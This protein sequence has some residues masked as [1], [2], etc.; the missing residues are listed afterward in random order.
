MHGNDAAGHVVVGDAVEAGLD[1]HALQGFLVRVHADR[2]GEVTVALGVI[3]DQ[4]ASQRHE[5]ERVGVVGLGHQLVGRLGELQDQQAATGLEHAQHRTDGGVL[6]GDVAQ[7]E[8]DGHAV[9]VVVRERQLFSVGLDE[10]DVAGHATVKQAVT[11]NLEHRIVDV[12]QHHL[13]GRPDKTRELG[14][15]VTGTAA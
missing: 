13:P 12:G 4:L 14:R 8:S 10:L 5:G 15:Q 3:G 6:V 2:L 11:A 9:E 1:H 7:A